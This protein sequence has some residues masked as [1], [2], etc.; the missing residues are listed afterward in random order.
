MKKIVAL[1]STLL[2]TITLVGCGTNNESQN[3]SKSLIVGASPAPHAEILK[4]AKDKLHNQGIELQIKEFTD[5]VVPN[6]ALNEKELDANYFQHIPYLNNFNKKNGTSL[7]PVAKVHAEPLSAYSQKIK[8]IT[9]LKHS[10][11]IA[12]PNDNS[13]GTRA[14]KLLEKQGLIK[15]KDKNTE[16]ITEKD[17]SENPKQI[18]IKATEAAQLPRLLDEVDIAIINGNYALEAKLDT[19]N[20]LFLENI[21]DIEKHVNILATRENNKHDKKITSLIKV[22]NSDE[23]RKFIENKYGKAVLPAK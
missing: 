5:Y 9:E 2:L 15:L 7:V 1:I 4:F 13:N 19:K 8:S 14:L 6:K 11:T 23:C 16:N 12:I 10:S 21:K 22:L 18:K 17:I 20:V 3:S